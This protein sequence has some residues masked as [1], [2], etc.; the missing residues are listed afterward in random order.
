MAAST[1]YIRLVSFLPLVLLLASLSLRNVRFGGWLV[2][3]W[4]FPNTE[5]EGGVMMRDDDDEIPL[6]QSKRNDNCIPLLLLLL[7]LFWD[8]CVCVCECNW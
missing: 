2:G 4:L 6:L 8:G 7:L 5:Q 3:W 1:L